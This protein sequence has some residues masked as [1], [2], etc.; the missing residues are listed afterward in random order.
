MLGGS[1]INKGDAAFWALADQQHTRHA[2]P[3]VLAAS[4]TSM[5]DNREHDQACNSYRKTYVPIA[6]SVEKKERQ[7]R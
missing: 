3:Q 4:R 6:L 5:V 7:A 1:L 2:A